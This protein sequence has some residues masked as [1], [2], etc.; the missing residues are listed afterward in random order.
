[1]DFRTYSATLTET[2]AL[3]LL[4]NDNPAA[5]SLISTNTDGITNIIADATCGDD[6]ADVNRWPQWYRSKG[7]KYPR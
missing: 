6:A 2:A 7:I 4:T 1:M 5:D 3:L